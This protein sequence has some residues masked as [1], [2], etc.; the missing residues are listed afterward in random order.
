MSNARLALV[1]FGAALIVAGVT[2][3]WFA[4]DGLSSQ[5]AYAYFNFAR[6]IQPHL[7][8][9]APLPDL[10]W[11]RG[12]PIAVALLL[13]LTGGGSGAGQLVSALALAGAAAATTVLVRALV[14]RHGGTM[15]SGASS[16]AALAAGLAVA[17]TGATLRYSQL[18][19]ADGLAV[20]LVAAA[21]LCAARFAN[22]GS[23]GWLIACAAALAGGTISRWLVGLLVVPLAFYLLPALRRRP[24]GP[25]WAAAAAL[26]GLTILVPQ[27]VVAR[28]I[29]QSFAQHEWVQNWNLSHA[30]R[31]DFDTPEGHE[32]YRLPIALFYFVR[33]GWPDAF[34]PALAIFVVAG[35]VVLARARDWRALALLAGWPI[36]VLVFLAGI[37]YENPR[38][39]LPTLPAIAALAGIGFG[40]AGAA[41]RRPATITLAASLALGV[42]LGAREHGRQVA[43]KNADLDL[44]AWTLARVPAGADLLMAGPTLAFERYGQRSVAALFSLTPAEVEGVVRG[45]RPLYVLA[46]VAELDRGGPA[47]GSYINFARL[48]RDPGLV[49]LGEHPP[50]TLFVAGSRP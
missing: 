2:R 25:V 38:F 6:A 7:W 46:D 8:H 44:I 49:V 24:G 34:F 16:A 32:R 10:Y 29:P 11:P 15:G 40:A 47:I 31:R 50:Y 22:G 28:A 21:L 4:F 13:P 19:M 43:R 17:C 12:Y 39:L 1:P 36:A 48:R 26:V 23:G 27:L 18:V 20:G 9:G 37:P 3:A 33:L 14:G 35:L 5:D 45:R 41:W 30:F 42:A